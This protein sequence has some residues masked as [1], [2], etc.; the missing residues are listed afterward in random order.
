[1]GHLYVGRRLPIPVGQHMLYVRPSMFKQDAT[2][3]AL[4]LIQRTC[5]C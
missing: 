1:V 3:H 2:P 5:G 4:M